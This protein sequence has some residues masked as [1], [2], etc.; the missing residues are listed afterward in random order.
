MVTDQKHL[1]VH[2]KQL[3]QP[4]LVN[5][6]NRPNYARKKVEAW[7][8]LLARI[9]GTDVGAL[10]MPARAEVRPELTGMIRKEC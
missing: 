8:S 2:L 5:M 7:G 4:I 10:A 1:L 6:K 9:L 3:L